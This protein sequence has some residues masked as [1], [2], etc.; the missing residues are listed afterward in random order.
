MNAGVGK[1]GRRQ[2]VHTRVVKEQNQ[3]IKIG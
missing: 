2:Y 1:D 3:P